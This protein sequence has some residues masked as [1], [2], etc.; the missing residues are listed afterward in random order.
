[1]NSFGNVEQEFSTQNRDT[2]L[3]CIQHSYSGGIDDCR[4]PLKARFETAVL[5]LTAC[6][7][8]SKYL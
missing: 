3:L 7:V 6:K 4:K 5:F 1:M 2:P 8:W